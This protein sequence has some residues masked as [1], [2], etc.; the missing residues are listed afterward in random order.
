MPGFCIF[1]IVTIC[2]LRALNPYILINCHFV[3][4]TEIKCNEVTFYELKDCNK[5]P[6]ICTQYKA[7][8]ETIKILQLKVNRLEQLLQ[9][10]DKRITE[11]KRQVELNLDNA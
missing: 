5:K 10:K 8:H 1:Q 3:A 7:S 9:L 11:L 6:F 2:R 4:V